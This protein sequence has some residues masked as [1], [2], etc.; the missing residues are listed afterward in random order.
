MA[1]VGPSPLFFW[2]GIPPRIVFGNF[3]HP[4]T[5]WLAVSPMAPH[6][7]SSEEGNRPPFPSSF[8]DEFNGSRYQTLACLANLLGRFATNHFCQ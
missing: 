2:G 1:W 3:M 5:K 8:Q 4:V 6:P 7:Y